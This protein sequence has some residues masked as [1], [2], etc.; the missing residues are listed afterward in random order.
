MAEGVGPK[1][2]PKRAL[3]RATPAYK[4]SARVTAKNVESYRLVEKTDWLVEIVASF[5]Q[6]Q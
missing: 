5:R 3:N 1:C 6:I 2:S 4:C